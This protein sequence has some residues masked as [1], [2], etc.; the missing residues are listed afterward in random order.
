MTWPL[1]QSPP[2]H[3]SALLATQ[4]KRR[5]VRPLRA[6]VDD[7][8]RVIVREQK[9]PLKAAGAVRYNERDGRTIFTD[10]DGLIRAPARHLQGNLATLDL[11]EQRPA[12]STVRLN[13][14]AWFVS[15][16]TGPEA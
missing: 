12:S 13:S 11:G 3:A 16:P 15:K 1:L 10:G 6:R 4:D 2:A 14:A 5:P 9:L 7:Q 8:W